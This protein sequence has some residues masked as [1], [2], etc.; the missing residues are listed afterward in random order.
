MGLGIMFLTFGFWKF[1]LYSMQI[2]H[3]SLVFTLTSSW[4]ILISELF[5][6]IWNYWTFWNYLF[7]SVPFFHYSVESEIIDILSLL[8]LFGGGVFFVNIGRYFFPINSRI[9]SYYFLLVLLLAILAGH[10]FLNST[11]AVFWGLVVEKY[12]RKQEDSSSQLYLQ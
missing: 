7:G 4:N 2:Q 5:D 11:V 8:G 6:Y 1:M 9:D 3:P 10:V 12:R